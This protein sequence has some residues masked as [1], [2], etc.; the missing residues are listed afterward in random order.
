[1]GAFTD[2]QCTKC[3]KIFKKAGKVTPSASTPNKCPQ[4]IKGHIW[5]LI[6]QK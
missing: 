4:N 2:W 5:I 6:K 1:M 3:G